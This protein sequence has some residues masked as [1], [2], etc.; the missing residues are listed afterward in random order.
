MFSISHPSEGTFRL[1]IHARRSEFEPA[2]ARRLRAVLL[3]LA[4]ELRRVYE[5]PEPRGAPSPAR[6]ASPPAGDA[7]PTGE[8]R[9]PRRARPASDRDAGTGLPDTL[10]RVAVGEEVRVQRFLIELVGSVCSDL[11]L[12][13]GDHVRVEER[14]DGS[15]VVTN[16]NGTRVSVPSHHAH[17]VEVADDGDV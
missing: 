6:D 3:E 1:E 5:E 10:A 8:F 7:G 9:R 15:V 4:E 2:E 11:G 12:A 14:S 13:E 17:F 16:G